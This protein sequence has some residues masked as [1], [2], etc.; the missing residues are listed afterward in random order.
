MNFIKKHYEKIILCVF[1]L[2]FIFSLVW[3]IVVLKKSTDININSCRLPVIPA[4]FP[5]VNMGLYEISENFAKDSDWLSKIPPNSGETSAYMDFLVTYP[6]QRCSSCTKIIP[7]AAFYEEKCPICG[8][9]LDKPGAIQITPIDLDRDKDMIPDELESKLGMNPSNP[10]DAY[11]DLDKDGFSNIYEY[12]KGTALNDPASRPD[13]MDRIYVKE[14]SRKPLD[15][16]LVKVIHKGDEKEKWEI[17]ANV[18]LTGKKKMDLKFF[19]LNESFDINKTKFKIIDIV[20]KTVN[21][22]DPKLKAEVTEDQS[23][24]VIQSEGGD[25]INVKLNSP[26]YE[27][28]DKITLCDFSDG[29]EYQTMSGAT[30]SLV[31]FGGETTNMTVLKSDANT[32]QVLLKD[33]KSGKDYQLGPDCEYSKH[34]KREASPTNAAPEPEAHFELVP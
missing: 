32:K 18:K 9:K 3:A 26:V 16:E 4:S 12:K 2:V 22:I 8:A 27:N 11:E 20:P 30:F 23:E 29:K 10:D 1:L 13:I 15:F 25:P 5:R 6:A 24:I 28:K 14:I 21:K 34:S 7:L 17:Q 31:S 19:K 33:K